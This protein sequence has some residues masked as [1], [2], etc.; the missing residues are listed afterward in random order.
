MTSP[1][2][3]SSE[4]FQLPPDI[5][6][7]TGSLKSSLKSK[8]RKDSERNLFKVQFVLQNSQVIPIIPENR[9]YDDPHAEYAHKLDIEPQKG[10]CS[11]FD[12]YRKDLKNYIIH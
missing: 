8:N 5:L 4:D 7:K 3:S 6:N 12:L 10:T 9:V 2:S 1:A 11:N